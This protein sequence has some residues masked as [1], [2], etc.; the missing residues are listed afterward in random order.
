[1]LYLSLFWKR[2][3][4]LTQGVGE[5]A[6]GGVG[7][8]SYTCSDSGSDFFQMVRTRDPMK[9]KGYLFPFPLYLLLELL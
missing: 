4:T 8:Q 2:R 3:Q 1:M 9:D 5:Q 6:Q 7:E